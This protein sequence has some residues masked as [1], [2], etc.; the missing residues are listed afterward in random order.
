M[1]VDYPIAIDNDYVIWRA[2]HNEYWPALYMVDA[3]GHVRHH[4]FGE[5]DYEQSE[6]VIQQLLAEAG[7]GGIRPELVAV[8]ARG[9]EAAADLDDLNSAENYVGYE[10]TQNFASPGG[11]VLDKPRMYAAPA[12]LE[13]NQWGLSGNWTIGKQAT[14]L[15]QANGRILYRFHS[16]DL[17]LVM[18]PKS[19]GQAERFRVS[20]DGHPPGFAHGMD[21][22]EHGNGTVTEPR[23]FQLIRQ[24]KPI[25]D[26][27]FEIE[28]LDSGAEAFAFTFG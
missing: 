9:V 25:T 1:R 13:L 27:L 18:G 6:K 2:F 15:N 24:P 3:K 26:R 19:R 4:H 16:R 10:R 21:V 28:F 17:H 14:V 23:L 5:G 22:D 8:N 20:I 11:A 12:R 7:V